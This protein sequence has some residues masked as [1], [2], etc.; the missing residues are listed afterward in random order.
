MSFDVRAESS[1]GA[2]TLYVAGELD[3]ATGPELR[4]EAGRAIGAEG[5]QRLIVDAQGLEFIDSTGIGALLQVR[6]E[7]PDSVTL[8]LV[9]VH[10]PALRTLQLTGL[11]ALFGIDVPPGDTRPAD[12]PPAEAPSA[13]APPADPRS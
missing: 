8:S 12:A 10:G 6:G 1:P 13:D 2:V 9:N 4:R 3:L 7:L 5:I 11:T